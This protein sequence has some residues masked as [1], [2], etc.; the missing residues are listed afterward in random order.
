V[1][2]NSL[3]L[4]Y[5]ALQGKRWC[6]YPAGLFAGLAVT[7]WP[8]FLPVA[9]V[10]ALVILFA[11]EKERRRPIDLVKFAS[12]FLGMAALVWMPQYLLLAKHDLMGHHS[13]ARIKGIAQLGWL[14]DFVL[15]FVLLG[16]IDP[17]QLWVTVLSGIGYVIL[18]CTGI[19]GLRCLRKEEPGKKRLLKMHLLLML[20]VLILVDFVLG[21]AY[22]R[23]V[24]LLFSIPLASL[25]VY[26]LIGKLKGKRKILSVGFIAWLVALACGWNLY[27][28]KDSVRKTKHGYEIWERRA[29]GVLRFVESNTRY[30]EYIFATPWTYRFVVLGNLIRG[31]LLAHRD[32]GT[33]YS[34]NP[35]LSKRMLDHYN[36]IL[37][38][39]DFGLIKRTLSFYNIRYV[40]MLNGEESM[41]I[42]MRVLFENCVH[43]HRDKNFTVLKLP[44]Y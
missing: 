34:L 30:G 42:G 1:M 17:N 8:A 31:N 23:R 16:G 6:L 19:L 26:Y 29:T 24:Q 18:I 27:N 21:S 7:I 37:N 10:L 5:L 44:Y 35:D 11:P 41:H 32:G 33:Y 40:L 25:A 15:R 9:I 12:P 28:L 39:Y 3:T 13:I 43:V 22:S 38:S 20:G 2:V 14:P 4:V 36:S